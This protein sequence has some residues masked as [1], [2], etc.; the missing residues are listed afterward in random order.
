MR[1]YIHD[2]TLR[3]GE[4]T[5]GVCFDIEAKVRIAKQLAKL[6][7]DEIEAG[8]PS[9]SSPVEVENIKAIVKNVKGK[10]IAVLA[11]ALEGDIDTARDALKNADIPAVT[12][13]FP[14]SDLHIKK[15]LGKTKD[16][17]L[18]MVTDSVKYAK[19][20][21]KNVTFAP[22]DSTRASRRYLHKMIQH[23]IDAGATM[24]S[25]PDTVG[26]IQPTEFGRMIKGIKNITKETV[27]LRVHC[28]NDMGVAVANSLV[29]IENGANTVSGTIN[30]IGERVGNAALEEVIM[31]LYV[32]KDHY[33]RYTDIRNHEI[34]ETCRLI[35]ELS[36]VKVQRNKAI[37]GENAYTHT[38]G[39]HQAGVLKDPNTYQILFP[40][41]VGAPN[42]KIKMGKHVGRHSLK[43]KLTRLGVNNLSDT[44]IAQILLEVKKRNEVS[45]EDLLNFVSNNITY[46]A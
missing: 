12:I 29:A 27:N 10:R 43:D 15:K 44:D 37:I 8:F 19:R 4:Q 31:A 33:N 5:P 38:A 28:H 24:I 30:G 16:V 7:V 6:N 45:D 21:F 11:R 26:Y 35:S 9:P 23:A 3:D 13:F 14:A 20:F 18:R 36:G 25:I 2:T 22:E 39:I 17:A 34:Y 1:V 32:R 41:L 42:G 46:N 40:D